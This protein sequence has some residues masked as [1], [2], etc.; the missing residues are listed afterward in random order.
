MRFKRCWQECGS[1]DRSLENKVEACGE[2]PDRTICQDWR[3][4]K[5]FGGAEIRLDNY[6]K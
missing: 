2:N 3:G 6:I 1:K 5:L 4:R